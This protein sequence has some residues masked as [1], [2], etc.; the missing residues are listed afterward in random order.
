LKNVEKNKTWRDWC[1]VK[2]DFMVVLFAIEYHFKCLQ[3]ERSYAK[4]IISV[5]SWSDLFLFVTNMTSSDRL[6]EQQGSVCSKGK[7]EIVHFSLFQYGRSWD[8]ETETDLKLFSC[9]HLLWI[10]KTKQKLNKFKLNIPHNSSTAYQQLNDNE[11]CHK[12]F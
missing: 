1:L 6:V 7:R 3:N 10:K 9:T 12:L 5:C 11:M 2:R 4:K 8:V